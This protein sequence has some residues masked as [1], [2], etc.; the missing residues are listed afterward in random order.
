M[1]EAL[2]LEA[3]RLMKLSRALDALATKLQR[4]GRIGIY[5]PVHGQE[6]SV[7]GSAFA[8]DPARDWI[9]PATREQPAMLRHGL[10]LDRMLARYM[11]RIDHARIPDG[12]N[13]LPRSEAIAAQL[14]H[15][16][17]LAWGLKL[18]RV[19]AAVLVYL[20]EGAS[21]EGDFH[22][23]A[24]LAGVLGAP[25]VMFL[26]NNGYAISTPAAT[27]SAARSLAARA[28]GYGFDGCRV[29]GNDLFAVYAATRQALQ[30]ALDGHGPTLIE[31]LTYR[32][33]FHN[34]TD[35][36]KA[37]RDDAEVAQAVERDPIGRVERYLARL[38]R[39]DDAQAEEMRESIDR[40][41]QTAL[42]T[43]ASA[44]PPTPEAVFE[45]VYA[46]P[47]DRIR[48]QR[49]EAVALRRSAGA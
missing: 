13:L 21:S 48:R 43:A 4:L 19:R 37:Y 8:L 40:E 29:D 2:T 38:G 16:A 18:R 7:V 25:L 5:G 39:W 20:G 27:Q 23:S 45:H 1:S 17:G 26:Q 22:E 30:R 34:T 42:A 24:N 46:D 3:L 36:P 47:P 44:A 12:V 11:G 49:E 15:A 9:V 10:P 14:P 28:L 41:L 31:S 32:I 6:A 35:N 33:G